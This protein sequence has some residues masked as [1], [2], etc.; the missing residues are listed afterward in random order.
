[1]LDLKLLESNSDYLNE[2][3]K[4]LEGRK[5]NLDQLN[6]VLEI[7]KKRKAL[8]T[9]AETAKAYQNKVSGEIAVLKRNKEDASLLLAEM[10]KVSIQVKEKEAAAAEIEKEVLHQLSFLPNKL[11]QSVPFGL[12]S[13]DNQ[14]VKT[15]GEPKKFSFKA[16]EHWEL[17][18]KLGYID[19]D[20]AAKVTGARF[21]FLKAGGAQLERA[22][23]QFFM[24]THTSENGYTEVI[25]PF[26]SNEASL[27]GT[28]NLPKF[29]EDLFHLESTN[30]FLIP[31]A[32]V[33]IT[34][35]Y[36]DEILSEEML[37]QKFAAYS[38]CFRSEAGSHG[39]DTKGLIRQHQFNKVELMVFSHPQN[40]MELHEALT[41]HAEGVLEKLELPYKRQLLCSGDIGA[42]AAKCFD[43]EVHL[44]GS[45]TYREI[46]S[47]SNFEDFQARRAN[48][49][50]KPTGGGKPQF[51]HTINGSGLA[52]GRTL[53]AIFE[54]Y[55]NEDGTITV[56]HV[57]KKYMNGKDKI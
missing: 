40:S 46:S 5:Q 51:V 49:R 26:I 37:P 45:N 42:N 11:H 35:F 55:Q 18:E 16:K 9:E 13:D 6:R 28:G 34:N 4:T 17:G 23:I 47:C 52:V 25:P 20:R 38:P 31:T 2:Y 19:F 8:M 21:A 44:P 41:R 10:G 15:V 54:N 7:N 1:M 14:N 22:L 30:Y 32:E 43:L 53:V 39:R 24:D 12:S 56:P 36:R 27:F 33:P 48:I 57:L 3:K 50:F 29:K